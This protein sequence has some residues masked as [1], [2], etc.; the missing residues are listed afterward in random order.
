MR[1]K[2]K[3]QYWISSATLNKGDPH[4]AFSIV[5]LFTTSS[6]TDYQ[7]I[8]RDCLLVVSFYS[9]YRCYSVCLLMKCF[10]AS[11][12][13]EGLMRNDSTSLVVLL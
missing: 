12:R 8:V 7:M 13:L 11:S 10:I 9:E 2:S 6:T 3:V 5:L 1:D 4:P